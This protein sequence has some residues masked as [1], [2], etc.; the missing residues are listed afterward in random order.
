MDD[1]A[2]AG[3]L[4]LAD[5]RAGAL[6]VDALEAAVALGRDRDGVDHGIQ[7]I[8]RATERLGIGDVCAPDVQGRVRQ[9][10]LPFTVSLF[11]WRAAEWQAWE[12]GPGSSIVPDGERYI[13]ATG[14]VRLRYTLDAS[15]GATVR[16]VRLNRL[17][18][19]AV[20]AIR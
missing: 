16:E 8:E 7:A 13:S 11:N 14:E 3:A 4:R 12:V 9:A 10:N 5:D 17:D 20:G 1:L 19:T 2:D 18:V 15:L 6:G